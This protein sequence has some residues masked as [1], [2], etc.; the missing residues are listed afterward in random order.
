MAEIKASELLAQLALDITQMKEMLKL[1]S[2]QYNLILKRLNELGVNKGEKS[3][4]KMNPSS[5]GATAKALEQVPIGGFNL[6]QE[7][8]QEEKKE[9]EKVFQTIIKTKHAIKPQ[10]QDQ[11]K[12]NYTFDESEFKT[13]SKAEQEVFGPKAKVP[14][15]QLVYTSAGKPVS[16]AMVELINE[17]GETVQKVKT[18]SV[19]RW[20]ALIDPGKYTIHLTRRYDTEVIDYQQSFEIAAGTKQIE[21]PAPEAYRKKTGKLGLK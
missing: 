11:P 20:S 21:I 2:Y 3:Q 17:K 19:G 15:T 8:K 7:Q 4:P 16:I 5:G 14:V 9:K 13:T 1:Q 10:V 6:V 12:D 18:N